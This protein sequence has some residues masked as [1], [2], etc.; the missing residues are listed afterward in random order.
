MRVPIR[1]SRQSRNS[2]A[3]LIPEQELAYQIQLR[4]ELEEKQHHLVFGQSISAMQLF[5]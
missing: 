4:T 5:P 2:S 1:E 3:T